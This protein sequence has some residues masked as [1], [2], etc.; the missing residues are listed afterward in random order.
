MAI[1]VPGKRWSK[2]LQHSRVFGKHAPAGKKNIS[3][4]L[5]IT[6]MVDMFVIIVLFLIANFS[7]TGEVLNMNNAIHLPEAAH[8][9]E[10]ELAPVVMIFRD[11]IMIDGALVGKVEDLVKED[12]Y[13]N[14]P[15]LEEK[16]RDQ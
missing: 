9:Q 5:L 11:S 14:I 3:A 16:L 2:R 13:L 6:P 1:Q 12:S 8:V 15:P 4:D 10:V 7:A